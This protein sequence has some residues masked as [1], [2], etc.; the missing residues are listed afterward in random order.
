MTAIEIQ[1]IH[2]I[3]NRAAYEGGVTDERYPVIAG[4]RCKKGVADF[5]HT[6]PTQKD[7]NPSEHLAVSQGLMGAPDGG[8]PIQRETNNSYKER[9]PPREPQKLENQTRTRD[10]IC[11][12]SVHTILYLTKPYTYLYQPYTLFS[13][14]VHCPPRAVL[15]LLLS[16]PLTVYK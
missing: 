6:L 2:T 5:L 7:K 4:L 11:I 8:L 15:R 1:V 16:A 10:L 9:G 12:T 14:E 13:P 3:P